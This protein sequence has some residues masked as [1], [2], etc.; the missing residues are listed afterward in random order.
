[1]NRTRWTLLSLFAASCSAPADV[2]EETSLEEEADALRRNPCSVNPNPVVVGE[3]FTIVDQAPRAGMSVRF[4]VK[5]QGGR[6]TYEGVSGPDGRT[7]VTVTADAAGRGFVKVY[8]SRHHGSHRARS[9]CRFVITEA[10]STSPPA[11]CTARTCADAGAECGSADDGCGHAL[12]CG[13]CGADAVCDSGACESGSC[14]PRTCADAGAECGPTDDGC[15]GLLRCG[16]CGTGQQCGVNA[17]NQCGPAPDPDPAPNPAP[18]PDPDPTPAP[19]PDP[20]PTPAPSPDPDPTPAPS[21]DPDPAPSPDGWPSR[22][23]SLEE[24]VLELVNVRRSQGGSCGDQA[25]GP[26]APLAFDPALRAAAR[27]HSTDMATRNYFSHTSLDG[28]SFHQRMLEAGWEGSCPCSENIA[29]GQSSAQA[30]VEG[31]MNSPGHCVNILN[32]AYAFIGIGY[33]EST[34]SSFGRYWTQDFAAR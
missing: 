28:R 21:P 10:A 14:T 3:T 12:N 15:G 25:F 2:L 26:S 13:S 33:A 30:V 29:A 6:E 19:S 22:W 27:G 16:G 8:R 11:S 24:Q 20:D 5:T 34:T 31:W 1:M 17:A 18:S 23:T 7:T 32:S 4:H 9:F